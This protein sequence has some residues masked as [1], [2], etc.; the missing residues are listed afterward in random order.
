M[1]DN[2]NDLKRAYELWKQVYENNYV[3][4]SHLKSEIAELMIPQWLVGL[5][6]EENK[7]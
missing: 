7:L 2:I 1:E 6:K 5:N 3:I 4:K